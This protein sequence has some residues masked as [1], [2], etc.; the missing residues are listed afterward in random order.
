LSLR[1]WPCQSGGTRN[2]PQSLGVAVRGSA[3][4]VASKREMAVA[5]GADRDDFAVWLKRQRVRY[6]FSREANRRSTEDTRAFA[7]GF[8]TCTRPS[9]SFKPEIRDLGDR[10]VAIGHV[11]ARGA[12]SEAEIEAA[13]ATVVEFKN[14]KGIRIRTYLDPKEALEAA[15]LS[16]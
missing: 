2:L 4:K 14:G 3:P 5:S 6:V 9:L 1:G 13:H 7:S 16:E 10:T 11:R 8:E 15:G 12:A